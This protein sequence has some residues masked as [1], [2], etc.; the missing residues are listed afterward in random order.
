MMRGPGRRRS[1][2]AREL[3]EE[4]SEVVLVFSG[5]GSSSSTMRGISLE[6]E[7]MLNDS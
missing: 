3:M 7:G 6:G 1:R 5:A 2:G 4:E